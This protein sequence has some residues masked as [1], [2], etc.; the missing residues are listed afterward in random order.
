M[1]KRRKNM[2]DLF[3]SIT[4]E[5]FVMLSLLLLK[6]VRAD[7][8]DGLQSL[9]IEYDKLFNSNMNRNTSNNIN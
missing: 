6:I 4:R 8:I 7:E 1:Y 5:E 9:L 3:N 2:I